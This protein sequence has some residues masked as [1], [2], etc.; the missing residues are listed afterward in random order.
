MSSF[1]ALVLDAAKVGQACSQTKIREMFRLAEEGKLFLKTWVENGLAGDATAPVLYQYSLDTTPVKVRSFY[2]AGSGRKQSAIM[3]ADYLVQVLG[4][5]V[6]GDVEGAKHM[7]LFGEPI[8]L[9][10][11]KSNRAL[12]GI[13]G[14]FLGWSGVFVRS[15]RLRIFHQIH[16]RGMSMGLRNYL[17]GEV[18]SL[19]GLQEE[20]E[21]RADD[22]TMFHV[23]SGCCLHDCHNSLRWVWTSVLRGTAETLRLLYTGVTVY[24][25]SV[26]QSISMLSGWLAQVLVA[27]PLDMCRSEDA[28]SEYYRVLGVDASLLDVLSSRMHLWWD[29]SSGRLEVVDSFLSVDG[30]IEEITSVLLQVWRFPGFVA[31]RWMTV[32]CSLRCLLLGFST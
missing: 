14:K 18:M 27:R 2:A 21:G 12:G 10:H 26:A 19:V 1:E 9:E 29:S 13:A 16:D 20:G 23:Q 11:G 6:G 24:R 30:C 3:P 4:V 5:T 28:L 31:S 25:K 7:L 32:G 17:S 22:M 15:E 8:L